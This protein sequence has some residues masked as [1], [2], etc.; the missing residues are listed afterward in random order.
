MTCG[1]RVTQ[2]SVSSTNVVEIYLICY[3]LRTVSLPEMGCHL[4]VFKCLCFQLKNTFLCSFYHCAFFWASETLG[5]SC[6]CAVRTLLLFC[7][8]KKLKINYQ[9]AGL[10]TADI[11][12]MFGSDP[13]HLCIMYFFTSQGKNTFKTVKSY[14]ILIKGSSKDPKQ[15]Y[16]VKLMVIY[17]LALWW[18][19]CF[20]ILK[21]NVC[22][23][24]SY[25][26]FR[27]L[28]MQPL[29]SLNKWVLAEVCYWHYGKWKGL[30]GI[31]CICHRKFRSDP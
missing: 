28:Y 17:Y 20:C 1:L 3:H 22:V 24:N 15:V 14:W 10:L 16:L 29:D 9:C 21:K 11:T 5:T 4:R 18:W 6:V 27:Y 7:P 19:Q 8:G 31:Y 2:D 30:S 12:R 23:R 25:T 13:H 26:V